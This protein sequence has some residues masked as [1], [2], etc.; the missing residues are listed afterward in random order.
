MR[1]LNWSLVVYTQVCDSEM[2]ALQ[3]K[4]INEQT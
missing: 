1:E 2:T 3:M 4:I